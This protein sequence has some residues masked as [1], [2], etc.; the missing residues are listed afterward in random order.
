M[1][2]FLLTS[3]LIFVCN[4]TTLVAQWTTIC[5]TG[6][7][8][9]DNFEV[10][11]NE[12]YATGFFTNLCGI[13]NNHIVKWDGSAWQ[14]IIGSGYPNAGHQLK[15]LGNHLYFVGYQP[16]ID[17]NWVY[18][19]GGTDFFKMGEG[20][21]LTNAVTGGSQTANLYA[22]E[23]FNGN[24][25]ACGEF[26]R[27]GTR[28]ISGIMQWDGAAWDSLGSGLSG[29]IAGAAPILYPHDLCTFGNDL[30]VA[31]NFLKAG[32]ITVNGIARWDGTQWHALG[33][34]F[35]S[36]VYGIA[37]FNG[38]LYAGGGFTASGTTPLKSI[39]KWNGTSW[40]DPGFRVY[41]SNP[42]YYS[43]VHTLKVL[44]SKLYI[45]GGFDRVEQGSTVHQGQAICAFDGTNVDTLHGGIPNREV[46][47]IA[48]YNGQLYAGG[49]MNNMTSHIAKYTSTVSVDEWETP[50]SWTIQPNPAENQ[51]FISGIQKD[52]VITLFSADGKRC[53]SMKATG[54][55]TTLDLSE[56]KSGIYI[57]RI[58]EQQ[59]RLV[60]K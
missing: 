38:E 25:I 44:N 58:G 5:G 20:V 42:A 6:N 39:A 53:K 60:K 27:V 47:A 26:N 17:S 54:T 22:L 56:L 8:F 30:I 4:V 31:G 51:C 10:F 45:A 12:L 59:R 21:Y 32:G 52:A 36:T 14:P 50:V 11:N 3:A 34:G 9:V 35:N 28:N 15:Y 7:G 24:I 18:Q 41:Y 13:P 16:A 49:G 19:F 46:E 48:F 29:N 33:A 55:E 2:K 57:V 43:F 1:R 40:V 23:E 37:V